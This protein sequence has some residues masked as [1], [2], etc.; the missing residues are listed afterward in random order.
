MLTN[1][2]LGLCLAYYWTGLE[3]VLYHHASL[4]M[5]RPA[6]VRGPLALKFSFGALWPYVS[7]RNQEFGWF[8]SCFLSSALVVSLTI[9]L[10]A[11]HIGYF[12]AVVLIG[13]VRTLP[14]PLVSQAYTAIAS[15]ISGVI[16]AVLRK[17]FGL[18]VPGPIRRLNCGFP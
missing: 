6:Y 7:M 2:L 5:D 3:M 9:S 10:L 12:W 15:L 16:F 8:L 1:V 4:P 11:G 13:A 18:E 17:M 14:I